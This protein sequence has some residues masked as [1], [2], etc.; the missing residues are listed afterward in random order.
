M[1]HHL[2]VVWVEC[3]F[4]TSEGL[5]TLFWYDIS[6]T[7]YKSNSFNAVQY[8]MYLLATQT[9]VKETFSYEMVWEGG[10]SQTLHCSWQGNTVNNNYT[11]GN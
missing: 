11:I 7:M 8:T 5:E 10:N 2:K 9:G 3:G 6:S 4:R 1:T